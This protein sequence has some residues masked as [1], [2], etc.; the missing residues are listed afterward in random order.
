MSKKS[1]SRATN[2]EP[3][4]PQEPQSTPQSRPTGRRKVLLTSA[5][6][7]LLAIVAGTFLY[8]QSPSA[9]SRPE[10]ASRHAPTIG[11]PGAKVH[12]VEFLDPACETCAAFYPMV[13]QMM[14]DN[15]GKIRLSVRHVAFHKGSDYVVAVLEA[16][17]K[18]GKYWQTLEAVLATQE[19][20]VINHT[21]EPALARQAI[22]G[23]GVNF[24]QLAADMKAPEVEQ[25]MTLDRIEAA[26]LKVTKTPEYF[27]NGRQMQT[28]GRQQLQRL[29]ADEIAKAYK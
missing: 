11:D 27:V 2:I 9:A 13:K 17:R 25:R 8:S 7:F 18:Q 28:F 6:A 16:S 21:V 12:I 15:P 26:Q 24:E 29:V 5:A 23:V 19:R 22:A 1:K 3:T 14:A 4:A 20:W 10:L